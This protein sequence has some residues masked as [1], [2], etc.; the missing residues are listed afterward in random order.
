VL[1]LHE[2]VTVPFGSFD[3][4]LKT[5]DIAPLPP[6][7]FENKFYARGIGVVEAFTV[8]GGSDHEELIRFKR[9]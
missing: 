4:V 2:K 8:K 6:P 5:K 1:S 7:A 9:G 3:N